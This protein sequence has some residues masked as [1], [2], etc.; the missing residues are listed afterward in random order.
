MSTTAAVPVITEPGIFH[1]GLGG[2]LSLPDGTWSPFL[3]QL[4]RRPPLGSVLPWV[5]FPGPW[6]PPG[7]AAHPP[8]AAPVASRSRGTGAGPSLSARQAILRGEGPVPVGHA[9]RG[10]GPSPCRA[11]G[12]R[13]QGG[14][15]RGG[16][17]VAGPRPELTHPR[18]GLCCC[19]PPAQGQGGGVLAPAG[20]GLCSATRGHC[21]PGWNPE[22]CLG[23]AGCFWVGGS[24]FGALS[25]PR[26]PPPRL[27][28][29]EMAA[30]GTG[31]V[32]ITLCPQFSVRQE[33][34]DPGLAHT[35]F[36]NLPGAE[37]V[38]GPGAAVQVAQGLAPWEHLKAGSPRRPSPGAPRPH[39]SPRHPSFRSLKALLTSQQKTTLRGA[40]TSPGSSWEVGTG[41][42]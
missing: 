32:P 3:S 11:R 35:S 12:G 21:S 40:R 6:E 26:P 23:R 5:T 20:Q 25:Q 41:G 19:L 7:P 42:A 34:G 4:R 37:A 17:A 1:C 9:C 36:Q 38:Q 18:A 8:R 33:I 13:A 39:L 24:I 14:R 30:P 27:P 28:R 31:P 16:R 15:A 2:E 29:N 22:A 10:T